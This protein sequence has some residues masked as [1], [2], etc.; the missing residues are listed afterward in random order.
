MLF[1]RYFAYT[2]RNFNCNEQNVAKYFKYD[3]TGFKFEIFSPEEMKAIN[4]QKSRYK[5]D[6]RR[7]SNLYL[8][9]FTE[10]T[11]CT[12]FTGSGL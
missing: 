5:T 12:I 10:T 2:E 11:I 7:D 4:E 9:L 1:I 3:K 8:L 6:A